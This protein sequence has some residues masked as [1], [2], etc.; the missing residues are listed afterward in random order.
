V[1]DIASRIYDSPPPPPRTQDGLLQMEFEELVTY[2]SGGSYVARLKLLGPKG[3][4]SRARVWGLQ[5]S[6]LHRFERAFWET[7]N[8]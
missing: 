7:A 1:F 8:T 2:L 6:E 5:Y 3:L 4:L